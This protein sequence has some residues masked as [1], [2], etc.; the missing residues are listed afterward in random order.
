M[1]RGWR[2]T[3]LAFAA[4]VFMLALTDPRS[5]WVPVIGPLPPVVTA[6]GWALA[7]CGWILLVNRV[8]AAFCWLRGE[9]AC[10]LPRE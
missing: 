9:A 2:I 6:L 5:S 10:R 8:A 4:S 7:A 1:T 3:A